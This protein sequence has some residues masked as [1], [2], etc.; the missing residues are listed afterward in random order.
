ME[1]NI[2][3]IDLDFGDEQDEETENNSRMLGPSG[4]SQLLAGA[5][6]DYALTN[7]SEDS[8]TNPEVPFPHWSIYRQSV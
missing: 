2:S 4:P 1:A 7:F 3:D 6:H 8:L 5:M